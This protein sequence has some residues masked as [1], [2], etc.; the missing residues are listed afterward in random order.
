MQQYKEKVF[1]VHQ[2]VTTRE[3]QIIADVVCD[4]HDK[5]TKK[6]EEITAGHIPSYRFVGECQMIEASWPF[7]VQCVIDKLLALRDEEIQNYLDRWS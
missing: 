7:D 3:Q 5:Y 2:Q 6:I 1:S 4:I